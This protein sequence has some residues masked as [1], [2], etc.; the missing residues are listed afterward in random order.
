MVVLF[1]CK[2]EENTIKNEGTR[3]LT[4][5]YIDFSDAQ[6]AGYSAVLGRIELKF[7]LIQAYMI[8][9]ITCKNDEDPIKNE[10]DRVLTT[11]PPF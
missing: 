6:G 4:R 7:K 9:L 10:G 1:T 3:V 5:L 11:F 8:V 2:Y